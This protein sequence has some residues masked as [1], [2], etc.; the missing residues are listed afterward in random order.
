MAFFPGDNMYAVID[1]ETRS[2]VDLK[3]QGVSVYAR[4]PSTEVL[5]LGYQVIG[6]GSPEEVWERG[7]IGPIDLFDMIALGI[8]IMALV[9]W[10]GGIGL[11]WF[12]YVRSQD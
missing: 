8:G 3:K 11:I 2:L 12:W 1:F 7:D 10:L 5:C 6:D 9:V 4:H